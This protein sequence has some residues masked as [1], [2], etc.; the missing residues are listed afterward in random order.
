[1]LKTTTSYAGLPS[2]FEVSD[3]FPCLGIHADDQIA[4]AAESL[5]QFA[6]IAKL[7]IAR[8]VTRTEFFCLP[9]RENFSLRSKRASVPA[10]T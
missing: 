4:L 6:D 2:V 3:Q 9:C 7:L 1:M 8:E 10:L 5:P